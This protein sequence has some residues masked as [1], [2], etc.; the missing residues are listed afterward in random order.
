MV[1][2]TVFALLVSSASFC[3]CFGRRL[4]SLRFDVA[5]WFPDICLRCSS[6][7]LVFCVF[8]SV[9]LFG[10]SYFLLFVLNILVLYPS[11]GV[12][13][14]F[15][16]GLR[17]GFWLLRSFCL[18]RIS[19]SLR[20]VVSLWDKSV[21]GFL[22]FRSISGFA[23]FSIQFFSDSFES[24]VPLAPWSPFGLSHCSCFLCIV[25]ASGFPYLG[26]LPMG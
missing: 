24:V 19:G 3:R 5:S 13:G 18:V 17:V 1:A 15:F 11:P 20:D 10:S 12:I 26:G 4:L 7:H 6:L 8:C 22:I 21:F 14:V 23:R 16:H 25:C 9:A 2:F